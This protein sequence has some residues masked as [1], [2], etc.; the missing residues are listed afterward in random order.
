MFKIVD[1]ANAMSYGSLGDASTSG[2]AAIDHTPMDAPSAPDT[3][4]LEY[5]HEKREDDPEIAVSKR[6]ETANRTA[7]STTPLIPWGPSHPEYAAYQ[8]RSLVA[9]RQR[10]MARLQRIFFMACGTLALLAAGSYF[11]HNVYKKNEFCSH[12][13]EVPCDVSSTLI[14]L[15]EGTRLITTYN[16]TVGVDRVVVQDVR[17][18]EQICPK[19]PF[20]F[21]L[22][23]EYGDGTVRLSCDASTGDTVGVILSFVIGAISLIVTIM[24]YCFV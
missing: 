6:T 19:P 16:C 8:N 5:D 23:K 13:T 21:A 4:S 1:C 3:A 12:Y 14:G 20:T 10:K 18:C 7:N 15:Q 24:Y 9:T 2:D 17:D 22:L 11:A